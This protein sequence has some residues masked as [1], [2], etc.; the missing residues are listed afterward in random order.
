MLNSNLLWGSIVAEELYLAGVR[1]VCISPG[2]RSTPLVWGLAKLREI[3]PDLQLVVHLDERNAGFFALGYAK[4]TRTL[5]ALVCTSGTA[6]A[7]YFPAII[8]AHLSLIPLLVLTAD[9][10]PS[11][12]DCGAPQT[13]DQI[14]LYGNQVRYFCDVGLPHGDQEHIR[15]LRHTLRRGIAIAKGNLGTPPGPVH[16]NFPFPEPLVDQPDL[17][18]PF[19]QREA[20]NYT[21]YASRPELSQETLADIA[22]KIQQ[23]PHGVIILG[24]GNFPERMGAL[25]QE[26]SDRTGYPV[27]AEA[28]GLRQP[29]FITHYDS[30]LRS[31]TFC[32]AHAPQLVL[33]FGG[34][35]TS[36]SLSQWLGQHLNQWQEIAIGQTF[37][38]PL[39][40]NT[41]SLNCEPVIFL[42]ALNQQLTRCSPSSWW[43]HNFLTA[44]AKATHIT[45]EFTKQ[46]DYLWEGTI[47]QTLSDHLPLGTCL[48]VANSMPTR[49]LDTFF[50]SHQHIKVLANKGAN[51]IDGTISS[52]LGAAFHAPDPTVLICGDIAFYHDLNSLFTAHKYQIKLTILLLNNNGGGIF[53]YLA[54][55]QHDPPFTEFFSTPH[56]LDFAQLVSAFGCAYRLITNSLELKQEMELIPYQTGTKVLEIKIDPH[57]SCTLH[58][59]LWHTLSQ[60]I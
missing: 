16:L 9:R 13:S 47:Y 38:N 2:S 17:A 8:E 18:Y 48:Y 1:L 31:P 24:V 21:A 37:S 60:M 27:L 14:K 22:Q 46:V 42:E 50:H 53:H 25:L 3:R 57:H 51:G 19:L 20:T 45:R 26:L 5:P 35:P 7:H 6:P 4:R 28:I 49:D 32:H 56:N 44:E 30:F 40:G 12:R 55:T 23:C 11:L 15:G 52:A 36:K 34:M 39:G 41:Y 33:R 43:K 59:Q 54:I 58:H 10:P 29:R